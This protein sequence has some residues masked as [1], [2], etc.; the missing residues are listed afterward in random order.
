[1]SDADAPILR[2]N[3]IDWRGWKTTEIT[4]SVETLSGSF[5][6]GLTDRWKE[7][8]EAVPIAAGMSCEIAS[9]DDVLITGYI[10]KLSISRS[11]SDH[12]IRVSGRDKSGDL[13]DCSAMNTP[14]TWKGVSVETLAKELCSPFGIEITVE[15]STGA[16]IPSFALEQGEKVYDALK[17]AAKI[18]GLLLYPDGSG[19]VKISAIGSKEGAPLVEGKNVLTCA[20]EYDMSQ[21]FSDYVVK[22]QQQSTDD[23]FGEAAAGVSAETKD[24]AVK[25]YR[26]LVIR[27]ESQVS[28]SGAQTRAAWEASTRAGKSV[29][30]TATVFD[31]RQ[32]D[33]S[34]WLPNLLV[35]CTFPTLSLN[36]KLLVASVVH[37]QGTEGTISRMTL[38]S[39]AAY[40]PEPEKEEDSKKKK[41]GSGGGG[42]WGSLQEDQY[43]RAQAAQKGILR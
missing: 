13:I 39:P 5:T 1:M 33:G 37:T 29:T 15:G 17:R 41:G 34:L 16:S 36:E 35:Q 14:G 30:V 2:I 25:R 43:D 22:G 3:G 24:P 6:L 19:K 32:P 27:A 11:G 7:G 4:R 18:R 12:S 9:R 23:M 20:I 38:R 40:T 8:Q 28:S 21:R 31:W 10:D 26:P 42:D